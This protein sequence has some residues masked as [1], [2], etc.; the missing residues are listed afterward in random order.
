MSSSPA[1]ESAQKPP[2]G[3]VGLDPAWSR[4]VKAPDHQ[5]QE[6][7]WHLLDTHAALSA[8]PDTDITAEA[9]D[10]GRRSQPTLTLLCVHGNPSW[11]FLWRKLLQQAPADVRVIAVD[12]LDMGFSER[13]GVVRRL[14]NRIDDLIELSAA[15]ELAGPVFVVAHDWGGPVA[16][17][18]A[19][20]HK[21]SGGDLAGVVLTNTAV[22]QPEGSAAPA[23][24]RATRTKG[25]LRQATVNTTA[26]IHA[27][28]EMSRPRLDPEVRAGFLAPYR[29]SGRREAIA[30]FVQ[31]I[32]LDPAHPS[33]PA[34]AAVADG[35]AELHDVPVLLL[36]GPS[37]LVF[38]DLYLHDLE[39]RL[40]HAD[41]HR[42]V[43][44]SHFVQEQADVAGAVFAWL[45]RANPVGQA[46]TTRV[47][48]APL[49]SE[50]DRLAHGDRPA[51]V[52]LDGDE[53]S[54]ITFSGLQQRVR[55]LAAGLAGRGVQ[56]R[57]RVAILIPPGIDLTVVLY[58]CWRMG[59]VTVLVDSGLGPRNMS[60]AL[61]SAN[62]DHLIG[63]P[64]ALAAARTLRWPGE[65]IGVGDLA[66]IEGEGTKRSDPPTPTADDL[67][68]VVFT[69]GST[70][71]SKGVIYRHHQLQAQ[72]DL[73]ADLYQITADD[74][75]VAAFAPF[76]LYG[77]AL[78]ITSAVPDMDVT[79]PG[80]L[81]AAALGAAVEAVGATLIFASPA[82]LVNVLT[83]EHELG[84]NV[85]HRRSLRGV[86]L[87][88]SA[89][90]PVHADLLESL[91][92][93]MP[94]AEAHTPYGMTEVLPV[95]D[96]SLTE[97]RERGGEQMG[98]C[99][100]RPR[101]GV[102]VSID[103]DN[104]DDGF[105]EILVQADHVKEGYDR[106]WYTE[107]LASRTAG[108]HRT[109]DVGHI[110]ADGY[111]WV[112]GRVEHVIHAASALLTPISFEQ[113]AESV[114]S[115]RRAAAVGVGPEGAQV[116]VLVV[117]LDDGPRLR[118]C[119]ADGV[120]ASEVR[121]AVARLDADGPLSHPVDVAAVIVAPKL[122]VDRRHNSKIDRTEIAHW[123]S[124]VLAGGR[125]RRL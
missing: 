108:W 53:T 80:S 43:G 81:T 70:G 28:F 116:V 5:G 86:R 114:P 8:A 59:A 75:L 41:V 60:R 49:W 83:T 57:D 55:A 7:T 93:L 77:P 11:S 32:P 100:G 85:E 65:R 21:R 105:G 52:E 23:V 10:P 46:E 107:H 101:A 119:L 124:R 38:S 51:V 54:S 89:G 102:S 120:L 6:R 15:L 92:A 25:V 18:W 90:A 13:S 113:A 97:L 68:A 33:A 42:F 58:A 56:H 112:E 35:L 104:A 88:L 12:Q 64:R 50:L 44:A 96:I 121:A 45:D 29:T 71:P 20:Q 125:I 76:A 36:W 117:E 39:R 34:L 106:L 69:S 40:P 4:L 98:V 67:A 109:G 82:A 91:L 26:F 79:R 95:S 22:S 84:L 73:L 3:I 72:R 122:P 62:P 9:P 17:G 87:L 63:I 2:E 78:G 111:L 94:N 110:D 74:R 19:E 14:Q 99:V 103:Q 31:D 123:A 27:A 118:G 48:R 16:L 115:V 30:D 66:A 61:A 1:L 37:D 47:E 24:I